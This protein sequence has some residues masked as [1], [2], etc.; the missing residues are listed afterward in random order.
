MAKET[1]DCIM[2]VTA[3]L[4]YILLGILDSANKRLR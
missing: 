3:I 2:L 4:A 1:V